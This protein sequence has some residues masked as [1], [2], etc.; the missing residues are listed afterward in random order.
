MLIPQNLDRQFHRLASPIFLDSV[1]NNFPEFAD[2]LFYMYNTRN[3]CGGICGWVNKDKGVFVSLYGRTALHESFSRSDM[4]EIRKV[5]YP[6]TK[7]WGADGLRRAEQS[8]KA[9]DDNTI[10]DLQ[11]KSQDLKRHL[12]HRANSHTQSDPWF[13]EVR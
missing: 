2:N 3:G 10:E 7:H 8:E 11:R 4:E 1:K 6:Q 13:D 9:D 12:Y 5:L